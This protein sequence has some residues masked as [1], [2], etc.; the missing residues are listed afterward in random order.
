MSKKNKKLKKVSGDY[1]NSALRKRF[2]FTVAVLPDNNN[3]EKDLQYIKSALLYA[4]KVRLISPLAYLIVQLTD[5]NNSLNERTSVSLIKKV[6][7]LAKFNDTEFYNTNLPLIDQF[8]RLVHSNQYRSMPMTQKLEIRRELKAFAIAIH[9]TLFEMIGVKQCTELETLIKSGQVIIEKFD[10]SIDNVSLYGL[11]FFNKLQKSINNSYPLFDEDSNNLMSSVL[12]S[13]IVQLTDIEKRKI[14]HAGLA[15]NYIQRLPSFEQTSADELLDVKK[16]LSGYVVRFRSK[17]L[18]YSEQIQ[19]L[20][21]NKDF[22]SECQ[23]L[24]DKEVTPEIIEIEEA[25]KNNSFI[26]NIRKQFLGDNNIWKTGG[27]A[28]GLAATGVIHTFT[29]VASSDIS[30]FLTISSLAVPTSVI[31]Q[32]L[33]S[34]YSEYSEQK[35]KIERNDLYFYYKAK[36]LLKK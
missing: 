2:D 8:S 26:K 14:T 21:W 13:H 33:Y 35:K 10:T 31:G 15:N 7:P 16:S 12:N 18:N 32:K 24:F 11:E 20:P 36:K 25:T 34:A 19:S 6:M 4:D 1:S 29:R 22:A 28:V 9:D 23:I 30:G 17:L 5:E 3:L 27:L